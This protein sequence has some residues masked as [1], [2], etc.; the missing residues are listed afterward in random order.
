VSPAEIV[1]MDRYVA[2]H[3]L[4]TDYLNRFAEPLMLMEMATMDA[5]VADDLA[6]WRLISYREHFEACDLRCAPHALKAYDDLDPIARGAFEAL[7]KAMARLVE[8]VAI[9][10][11]ETPDPVVAGPIVEVATTAFRNLLQRATAF[12]NSGGDL[13]TAAYDKAE[14]QDAIDQIMV[15]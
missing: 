10:L 12:I 4:S 2:A 9:T 7:C 1:Q 14:L 5:G 8:T 15:A 13:A 11:K 6:A 3:A